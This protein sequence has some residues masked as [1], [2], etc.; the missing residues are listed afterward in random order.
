VSHFS[1]CAFV[2]SAISGEEKE[3]RLANTRARQQYR[4]GFLHNLGECMGSLRTDL[5]LTVLISVLFDRRTDNVLQ[6]VVFAKQSIRLRLVQSKVRLLRS[7]VN[8]GCRRQIA[9]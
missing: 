7:S 5:K 6:A 3:E 4:I 1:V 9:F 8:I 2:G